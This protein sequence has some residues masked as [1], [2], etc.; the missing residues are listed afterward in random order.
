M[1]DVSSTQW[2]YLGE[3]KVKIAFVNSDPGSTLF[4]RILLA[5]KS[6]DRGVTGCVRFEDE[7]MHKLLPDVYCDTNLSINVIP[8]D[9]LMDLVKIAS[10]S[11]PAGRKTSK[12]LHLCNR[13][14]LQQN[15]GRIYRALPSAVLFNQYGRELTVE[16]KVKCGLKASSPFIPFH[17]RVKL[18]MS[19]Y[20]LIQ[21][22]KDAQATHPSSGGPTWGK[23]IGHSNY[24]PEDL[25]SGDLPRLRR[26]L[27]S[28][29]HNPQ[30]NLRVSVDGKHR[31][32]WD[33][34]ELSSL[35]DALR[36]VESGTVSSQGTGAEGEAQAQE[37]LDAVAQI[38]TKECV[39]QRL[40]ALQDLDVLDVEGAA[41]V[42]ARVVNLCGDCRDAANRYLE[43]SMLQ[44]PVSMDTNGQR[45]PLPNTYSAECD[46]SCS[47]DISQRLREL[48]ISESTPDKQWTAYRARAT[49]LIQRATLEECAHLLQLFMIALIA[50]DAS[51]VL[52]L[53]RV[54][55]T[56]STPDFVAQTLAHCGIVR[57]PKQGAESN[58]Q[59]SDSM[60]INCG[61]EA[62][63]AAGD[64]CYAYTV[65]VIDLGLKALDKLWQK[66]LEE[67]AI[68][69]NAILSDVQAPA[70]SNSS[71]SNRLPCTVEC[72]HFT[73][74]VI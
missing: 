37:M 18:T 41:L 14:V 31:Y 20:Q 36:S 68:C 10:E 51:V 71:Q 27:Q 67:D 4:E 1:D 43:T 13:G 22:T 74:P 11:R 42:Y 26:S 63:T 65:G 33:E 70:R 56:Y 9:M 17:R 66:D 15:Y 21:H 73:V 59:C 46:D 50:R 16:L 24:M 7:V 32:G 53:K 52:A 34:V 64:V 29:L 62:D 2:C 69:Q 57:V 5:Y 19:R 3:G 25:C 44:P 12:P 49:E 6:S 30:N 72:N 35:Y 39:L 23:Y 55:T 60:T 48:R 8:A 47:S 38:L 58:T 40:Q 61:T 54:A 45:P 28:L